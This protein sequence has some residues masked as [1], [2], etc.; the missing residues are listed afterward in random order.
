MVEHSRTEELEEVT[1]SALRRGEIPDS[2]E[3]MQVT[4]DEEVGLNPC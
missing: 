3:I 2:D 1:L 4:V